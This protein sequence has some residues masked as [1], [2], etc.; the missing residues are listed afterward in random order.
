MDSIC[1]WAR[2]CGF[3]AAVEGVHSSDMLSSRQEVLLNLFGAGKSD[4]VQHV[5]GAMEARLP[6]ALRSTIESTLTDP[7]VRKKKQR[8]ATERA[9]AHAVLMEA[10][11]QIFDYFGKLSSP[12]QDHAGNAGGAGSAADDQDFGHSA[13]CFTHNKVCKL[14]SDSVGRVAP[15][16]CLTLHASGTPCE[17]TTKIGARQGSAGPSHLSFSIWL[18]ERVLMQEAII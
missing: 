9:H 18:A 6:H 1:S 14:F 17:D 12:Q 11:Q 16:G 5:H 2:S 3:A 15:S 10:Q 8:S 4:H 13:W 7:A